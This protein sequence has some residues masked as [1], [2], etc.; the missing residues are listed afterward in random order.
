M[1]SVLKPFAHHAL[2]LAAM[3]IAQQ[4]CALGGAA[5]VSGGQP[6]LVPGTQTNTAAPV[7]VGQVQGASGVQV[8]PSWFVT[9]QHVVASGVTTPFVLK[10]GRSSVVSCTTTPPVNDQTLDLALCRLSQPIAPPVGSTIPAVSWAPFLDASQLDSDAFE[11]AAPLLGGNLAV[12]FGGGQTTGTQTAAWAEWSGL[13][14]SFSPTNLDVSQ[15]ALKVGGDSGGAL[16]W[17]NARKEPLVLIGVMRQE[18]VLTSGN[19]LFYPQTVAWM[20][21]QILSATGET[22]GVVPSTTYQTIPSALPPAS[23]IQGSVTAKNTANSVTLNWAGPEPKLG[24]IATDFDVVIASGGKKLTTGTIVATGGGRF[25][26]TATGLPTG[27]GFTACVRPKNAV[28]PAPWGYAQSE[29]LTA[30]IIDVYSHCVVPPSMSEAPVLKKVFLSSKPR[31]T[32]TAPRWVP[33]ASVVGYRVKVTVNGVLKQQVDVGA[34]VLKFD[35]ASA[36]RGQKVCMT[37]SA[38]G[39]TNNPGQE[40]K[41]VPECLTY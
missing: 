37:V 6:V 12:G 1:I 24:A 21:D 27:A 3:C 41:S 28:G 36:S 15:L 17:I 25:T 26:A 8:A 13:P 14:L 34:S 32:W 39:P 4:A 38:V 18:G 40:S 20:R 5:S 31:I 10:H 29:F 16:F 7:F 9:A 11:Q 30:P 35:A 22:L 19:E 23:L 33:N 2:A